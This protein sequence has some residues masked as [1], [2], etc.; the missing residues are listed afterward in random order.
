[1]TLDELERRAYIE[2]RIAEAGL[3]A[4]IQDLADEL[5]EIEADN[6]YETDRAFCDGL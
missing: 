2:G 5:E 1:M 6:V 3:L 4:Q